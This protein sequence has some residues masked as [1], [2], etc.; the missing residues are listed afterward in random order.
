MAAYHIIQKLAATPGKLDKEQIVI[1]AFMTGERE[2]FIGANLA[3]NALITFGVK[4]VPSIAEEDINDDPG[5]FAFQDF[6]AL[7]DKLRARTLTGNAM[8]E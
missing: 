5:T 4:K 6:I 7:T 2:F 3:Y 8:Q 1:N